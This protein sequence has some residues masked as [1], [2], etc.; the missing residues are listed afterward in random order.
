MHYYRKK[1]KKPDNDE[2]PILKKSS[3]FDLSGGE[4]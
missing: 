3:E 2:Y 1:K 4:V